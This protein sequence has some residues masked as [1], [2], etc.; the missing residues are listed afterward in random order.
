MPKQVKSLV[1]IC[2][3]TLSM[4]LDGLASIGDVPY[5]LIKSALQR[6][7]AQQL[8]LIELHNP[9]LVPQSH[10][11]WL[12]H[13]LQYSDLRQALSEGQ[14]K[15]PSCWRDLYLTR[16]QEMEERKRMISEKVK[17]QYNKIRNEKAA[18]SIKVINGH[19]LP[20]SKRISRGTQLHDASPQTSRLFMATKKAASKSYAIYNSRVTKRQPVT[21]ARAHLHRPSPVPFVKPPSKLEKQYQA[22]YRRFGH[23][24]TIPN[25]LPLIPPS[26]A[27]ASNCTSTSEHTQFQRQPPSRLPPSPKSSSKK[28]AA[29]VNYNIFQQL[30]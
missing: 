5:S 7:T 16:Y 6:A 20:P 17:N 24:P 13:V 26:P 22:N 23:T 9:H 29:I 21:P 12:A 25:T 4:N 28:P 15:D 10:E 11:L 2:Q 19:H 18:R 30:T 27:A 14:Y 8:H 1:A 3:E